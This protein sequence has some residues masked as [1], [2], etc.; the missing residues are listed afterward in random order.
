[1]R[2]AI[3]QR[4]YEHWHQAQAAYITAKLCQ[5]RLIEL[6]RQAVTSASAAYQS[7][8]GSFLDV[9]EALD[10]LG[11]QQRTYYEHLVLLEQHVVML[12]QAAGKSL[13]PSHT[14]TSDE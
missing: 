5:D 1:M 9:I 12:E 14:V 4:V 2:S 13:R 8:S 11:E 10:R 3:A 7:G 6:A